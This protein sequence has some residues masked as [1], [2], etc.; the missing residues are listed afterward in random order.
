MDTNI[1]AIPKREKLA[2]K[3]RVAA[4]ARVSSGKESML[5]SLSYQVSYYNSYIQKHKDWLFAGVYA[6]EAISGTKD[7]RPEFQKLLTECRKGNVDLIVT[8]SVSRFARNTVTV[9]QTIR[10]LTLLKVDVFFEEQNLHTLGA[11]GE[12]IITALASYAEAEAKSVSENM[13][14]RIQKNFKEGL[15]YSMTVLGYRIVDS[16]LEVVPEEAKAVK[17][18]FELYLNGLGNNLIA[19]TMN[20]EGYS[21]RFGKPF[22]YTSVSTILRNRTYT[23]DLV[24]QTT[25]SL[26]PISKR[27]MKNKG[28]LDMYIVEDDHEPIVSKETFKKVQ[29]E[30]I[31]R[32]SK[33]SYFDRK[34]T[35]SPF[36]HKLE[37]AF[38]GRKLVRKSCR[39]VISWRCTVYEKGGKDACPSKQV[40]E[41]SLIAEINNV[42][43]LKEFNEELFLKKVNKIV[44]GS[45]NLLTFYLNDGQVVE[46]IYKDKSRKWT[47][48]M[49]EKEKQRRLEYAKSKCNQSNN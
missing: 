32:Q 7:E 39:G 48:E 40:P 24:L 5:H 21:T 18:I 33:H 13:K 49:K 47:P 38:D 30:I 12:L 42:L 3:I 44:V 15:I 9:L 20:K 19:Q 36:T 37:C 45:N 8:K 4:Y 26:D 22:N 41:L 35:V 1:R 6:D 27:T 16:H 11:E 14:W 34:M 10:E 46:R 28:E 29:T 2:K 43:S 25:Y 31:K 17:R 23:G